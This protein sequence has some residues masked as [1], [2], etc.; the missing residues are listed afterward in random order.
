MQSSHKTVLALHLN[1][2][3]P[4]VFNKRNLLE[5]K[6]NILCVAF[7]YAKENVSS[8]NALRLLNKTESKI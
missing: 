8:K 6:T 5:V 3:V 1:I 4:N 7:N 2:F